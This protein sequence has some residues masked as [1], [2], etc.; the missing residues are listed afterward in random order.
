M[1]SEMMIRRISLLLLLLLVNSGLFAADLQRI[2]LQDGSSINAEVL[3]LNHGTYTLRSPTLGKFTVKANKVQSIQSRG[4]VSQAQSASPNPKIN[5]E[6][7]QSSLLANKDTVGLI[8]SLQNDPDVKAILA[9][10]DIMAAIQKGDYEFLTNNPKI[11][12]LM[13]K[14]KIKKITGRVAQ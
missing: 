12:N 7:I 9:D 11:K 14:S 4:A 10:Q 2:L 3:S 8:M 5:I 13:K 1:E 6:Q